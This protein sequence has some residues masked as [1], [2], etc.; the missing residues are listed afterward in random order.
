MPSRFARISLGS[1][2]GSVIAGA[3]ALASGAADSGFG[4]ATGAL[5]STGVDTGGEEVPP[6]HAAMVSTATES[7]ATA[8]PRA[9]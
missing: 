4:V 7:A 5:A 2:D 6:P 3:L 9:E 1:N 8:R